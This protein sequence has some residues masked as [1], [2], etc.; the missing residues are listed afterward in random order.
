MHGVW[1]GSPSERSPKEVKVQLCK[2]DRVNH[3]E[4]S[5]WRLLLHLYRCYSHQSVVSSAVNPLH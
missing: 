1:V 4:D 3:M 2:Q 5:D